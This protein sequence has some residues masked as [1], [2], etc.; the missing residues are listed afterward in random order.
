MEHSRKTNPTYKVQLC[1]NRRQGDY[2]GYDIIH[3][4]FIRKLRERMN[5]TITPNV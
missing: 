5:K 3:Q 2:R 1:G 4:N